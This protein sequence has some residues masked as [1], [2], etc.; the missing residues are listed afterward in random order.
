MEEGGRRRRPFRQ[1]ELN[2]VEEEGGRLLNIRVLFKTKEMQA[3]FDLGATHNFIDPSLLEE[4][5]IQPTYQSSVDLAIIDSRTDIIGKAMVNLRINNKEF[6]F[7]ALVALRLRHKLVLGIPFV[8]KEQVIMDFHRHV[9]H[10]G[11]D[12]RTTAAFIS[13]PPSVLPDLPL[14]KHGFPPDYSRRVGELLQDFRHV[15]APTGLGAGTTSTR[16]CIKLTDSRPFRL[17]PYHYSEKKRTEIERQVQQMLAEGVIEP[18]HSPYNS[19]IVMAKKKDGTLRFCVDYRRLNEVTMDETQQIPRISDALKDLG[20]AKVFTTLDLKSGYWQIPMDET[21]KPYT[22]FTT[23]TGGSYQFRVMPFGLK[24]APGTFQR[25]MSQEVLSGYLNKF[26][27]VYLDDI[28]IYSKDW[29]SHLEHLSRVLERLSMHKL[30]CASDK[31]HIG[32]QTIEFLGFLVDPHGNEVKPSY[33][34]ALRETPRP[35]SKR[36]LQSFLGA[37]N[38]LREYVPN[39]SHLLQPLTDL[40]RK[41]KSFYWSEKSQ[42]DF[43]R[44]KKAFEGPLRLD[45]PTPGL[46]FVLQTDASAKGM[47]AV[48]YQQVGDGRRIIAYASAKFTPAESRYHCNEQECLAVVWA[49]KR[50]RPYLEDQPFTL[51]TDS[52]TITWL[53][54]FKGTRDKLLRWALLLQEFQFTVE[55][56]PGRLNELPDVLSRDPCEEAMED[57]G[58]TDRIYRPIRPSA[59][60]NHQPPQLGLIAGTNDPIEWI[61]DQQQRCAN[62]GKEGRIRHTKLHN[63]LWWAKYR[64]KGHWRILVPRDSVPELIRR[65]H[66]DIA[67]GHPGADETL[68]KIRRHYL[69]R[70]MFVDVRK[71]VHKCEV[72][73]RIK[74]AVRIPTPQSSHTPKEPWEI[75]AL[76]LMGPYPITEE[77]HKHILV[78]TDLFSRWVEAFPVRATDAA[79]LAQIIE[80]NVF[81]RWGFPRAVLTDNGPQF[82]GKKWASICATWQALQWTTAIY[83]PRANPT[84]RRNQEVKTAL[85]IQLRNQ[86]HNLWDQ[87]LPKIVFQLRN[88]KNAATGLTP[89]EVLLGRE[90]VLPG[91][92]ELRAAFNPEQEKKFSD[93]RKHQQDYQKAR[94]TT[95]KP[96]PSFV[97][98]DLV[99]LK[100]S[101][102]SKASKNVCASLGHEWE[103][104]FAIKK[105]I[106]PGL[107][108][109]DKRKGLKVHASRLKAYHQAE[110]ATR[111]SGS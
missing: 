62:P 10:L 13:H 2:N 30:R 103:G 95:D 93:I 11:R 18:S 74:K 98:G 36:E 5:E 40:L 108:I 107:Y 14:P 55:H 78:V 87:E 19:P 63:G 37:C 81:A 41:G 27:I 109:I 31:V 105:V 75:V 56:C 35:R 16:H 106:R 67:M 104:P 76:D 22:A 69:W 79:T 60:E 100:A 3:T 33:L 64:E 88:R 101:L 6:R 48:L 42:A 90:L 39:M 58:N 54:R 82:A 46:P 34:R 23:P 71:Y 61:K 21:A 43:E 8:E 94:T 57:R 28:I 17:A 111:V 72:C 49:I 70:G 7:L 110:V 65:H 97:A 91:E 50:F 92:W 99:L 51:R 26:C 85:R 96:F 15:L 73:Q 47:G 77:G 1:P 12:Q 53:N 9:V 45:R 32:E 84:E 4:G 80:E 89:S 52:R 25:L 68:R 86:P 38:W 44:A 29:N 59:T 24:G 66:D 83:H 102:F 20:D